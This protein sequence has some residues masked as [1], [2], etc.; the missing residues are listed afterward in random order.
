MNEGEGAKVPRCSDQ[1]DMRKANTWT[2][3]ALDVI[4]AQDGSDMACMKRGRQSTLHTRITS[5]EQHDEMSVK[6]TARDGREGAY[7][8]LR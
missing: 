3:N 6:R 5:E 4:T 2:G 7:T 1:R 8:R